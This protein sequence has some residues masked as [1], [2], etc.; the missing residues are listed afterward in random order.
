MPVIV[1]MPMGWSV[2]G[3]GICMVGM[4]EGGVPVW[5]ARLVLFLALGAMIVVVLQLLMIGVT[6]EVNDEEDE[7]KERKRLPVRFTFKQRLRTLLTGHPG[8]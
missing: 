6:Q 1:M 2:W 5:L 7:E 8:S 3:M 4:L